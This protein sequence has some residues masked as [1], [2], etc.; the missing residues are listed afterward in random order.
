M[1]FLNNLRSTQLPPIKNVLNVALQTARQT[2][3]GG[4]KPEHS[5]YEDPGAGNSGVDPT[6]SSVRSPPPPRPPAGKIILVVKIIKYISATKFSS[7]YISQV[8]G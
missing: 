8:Q 5:G 1:S 7:T 6:N 4:K 3:P 2:I